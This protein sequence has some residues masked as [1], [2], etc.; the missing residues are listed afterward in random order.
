[1]QNEKAMLIFDHAYLK[2]ILA[3]LKLYQ[4]VKNQLNS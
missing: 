2:I 4:Q 3:L 1:M